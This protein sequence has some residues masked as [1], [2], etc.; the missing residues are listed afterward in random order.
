M[1]K[2]NIFRAFATTALLFLLLKTSFAAVPAFPGAEGFGKYTTGGRGGRILYVTSLLDTNTAGT[3]RYAINQSG[4]RIVIFKVSGTITLT[5]QLDIKNDNI[6]IA[7]Q[8]A[9]GDGICLRGY[10][11]NSSAN[12]VIIRYLR[13]R[14]GDTNDIESDAFGGRQRKN[15][16]IE[17]DQ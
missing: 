2:I 4:P 1:I 7:G 13:F 10:G 11:V 9:P 12:N 3:L 5:S 15:I 16:I 14:M 8:T 6:T 17:P